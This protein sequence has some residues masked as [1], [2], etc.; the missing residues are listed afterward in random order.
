MRVYLVQHG[1]AE[2]KDVEPQRPLTDRGR[3]VT[4]RMAEMSA[5]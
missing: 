5:K 3:Q 1:E 2:S 4:Q